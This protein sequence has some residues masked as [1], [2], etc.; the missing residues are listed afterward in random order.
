MKASVRIG[1]LAGIEIRLHA[2]FLLVPAWAFWQGWRE[3]GT[4]WG[5]GAA[6]L[7]LVF[8]ACVLLHEIGHSLVAR[9]FGI[10]VRGITLLPVG[11]VALMS[12]LPERPRDEILIALAGP[13]TSVV[14]AGAI[15]ACR[16]GFAGVEILAT[17]SPSA[18]WLADMLAWANLGL[19]GFNLLPFFPMDGG[20]V[21]RALLAIRWPYPRATAIAAWLGFAGAVGLVGLAIRLSNP[22]MGLLAL[23]LIVAGRWE[24]VRIRILHGLRGH[25]V[26]EWLETDL[27]RLAPSEP[28]REA[29]ARLRARRS[30]QLPVFDGD[31]MIGLWPPARRWPP[32][33]WR[34]SETV[35]GGLVREWIGVAPATPAEKMFPHILCRKQYVFPV[36]RGEVIA[37]FLTRRTL[38]RPPPSRPPSPACAA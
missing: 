21:I 37:G 28:A 36:V 33:R 4:A 34:A 9:R 8:F 26:E 1:R 27:P 25:L 12:H 13:A 6:A 35:A 30:G 10:T 2:A 11:G 14:L 32:R 7:T 38:L 18:G 20:R 3:G 15:A 16:G 22:F 31:R 19:A 5:M 29:A 24:A 23:L 17:A